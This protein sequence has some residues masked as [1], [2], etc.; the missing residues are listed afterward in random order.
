MVPWALSSQDHAEQIED[1]FGDLYETKDSTAHLP[2]LQEALAVAKKSGCKD[3]QID[4][5][6]AMHEWLDPPS[7]SSYFSL[8]K[9][10]AAST[11]ASDDDIYL[12]LYEAES[13]YLNDSLNE[14]LFV[15]LALMKEIPDSMTVELA[16]TH[17]LAGAVMHD[18]DNLPLAVRNYRL[19]RDFATE[20]GDSA[21]IMDILIELGDAHLNLREFDEADAI[22]E[23]LLAMSS[24]DRYT[25]QHAF[26]LLNLGQS[27]RM[28]ENHLLAIEEFDRLNDHLSEKDSLQYLRAALYTERAHSLAALGKLDQSLASALEAEKYMT[29]FG[30]AKVQWEN[31][32]LLQSLYEDQGDYANAY[33]YQSLATVSA[34]EQELNYDREELRRLKRELEVAVAKKETGEE[35]IRAKY[36]RL[37]NYWIAAIAGLACIAAAIVFVLSYRLKTLKLTKLES[38]HQLLS[39][40]YALKDQDLA[41]QAISMSHS[42]EVIRKSL[43]DLSN[44]RNGVA[45]KHQRLIS[46]IMERLSD[47]RNGKIQDDFDLNFARVNQQFYEKLTNQHPDLS[48]G[49]LKLCALLKMNMSSKDIANLQYKSV[50][51]IEVAR[52]RLRKKL[53]ISNSKTNLVKYLI[54]L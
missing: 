41:A 30:Q 34:A 54:S 14:S 3:C 26:A 53:G 45:Q 31:Q 36:I 8:A 35:E 18:L 27:A 28:Q 7:G 40:D 12:K 44:L 15:L 20:A 33:K 5:Y 25:D 19:A 52:S 21:M 17:Q 37:R 49:D 38:D 1:I 24:D 46:T 16:Q 13:R 43:E 48:P 29:D 39:A 42:N 23:Q 50:G 9:G 2:L 11:L 32:V 10:V 47:A 6:V 51:S 22:F 4:V